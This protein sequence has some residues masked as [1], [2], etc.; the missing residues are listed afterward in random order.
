M[1]PELKDKEK[2]V[3][4]RKQ[5]LG[6]KAFWNTCMYSL[7]GIFNYFFHEASSKRVLFSIFFELML[8]LTL[9]A[10]YVEI[11]TFVVLL[12]AI[13][14][15]EMLNTGIEEIC[16]LVCPEYNKAIK[17]AKDSGS[18][19]TFVLSSTLFIFNCIIFIPKIIALF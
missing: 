16:D 3:G 6:I 7:S 8:V 17:I 2:L 9:K 11:L 13:T 4:K 1:K 10:S 12:A 14:A 15:V 19:A 18:G 5:K